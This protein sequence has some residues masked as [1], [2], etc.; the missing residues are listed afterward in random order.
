M[1]AGQT[2]DAFPDERVDVGGIAATFE[3]ATCV[4][5]SSWDISLALWQP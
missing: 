1:H 4:E 3:N 5:G 2:H